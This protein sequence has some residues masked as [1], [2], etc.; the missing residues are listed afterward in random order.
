MIFDQKKNAPS[1]CQAIY[2]DDV[3]YKPRTVLRLQLSAS[4]S[5]MNELLPT[6]AKSKVKVKN[7]KTQRVNHCNHTVLPWV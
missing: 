5:K 6:K 7:K 4:G 2:N 3:Y 1:L